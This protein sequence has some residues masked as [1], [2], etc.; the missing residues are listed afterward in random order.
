[1]RER[2]RE[3]LHPGGALDVVGAEQ[4]DNGFRSNT[5]ALERGALTAAKV[6]ID[7]LYARRLAMYEENRS[8]HTPVRPARDEVNGGET[9]RD[10]APLRA[11]APV[12]EPARVSTG[13]LVTL[14][15]LGALGTVWVAQRAPL[16]R[17]PGRAPAAH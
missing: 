17:G 15:V 3:L 2:D 4:G 9:A 14:T 7:E 10:K 13:L 6:D 16:K 5:P 8:F 11:P 12:A 1:M